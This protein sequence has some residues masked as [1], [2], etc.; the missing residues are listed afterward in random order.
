MQG[1]RTGTPACRNPRAQASHFGKLEKHLESGKKGP[2]V[3]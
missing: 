3:S 1:L 2:G